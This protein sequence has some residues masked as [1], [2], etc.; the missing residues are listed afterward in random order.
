[1][2]FD[3]Q[4]LIAALLLAATALF[5]ITQRL[6]GRQR[7]AVMAASIAVYGALV[8]GV[9]VYVGLWFAGVVDWR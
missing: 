4:R 8:V 1:M 2:Q 6:G 9:V 5:L 7:R 3:T